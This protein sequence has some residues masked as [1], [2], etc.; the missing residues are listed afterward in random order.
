MYTYP[1]CMFMYMY[2][3][4]TMS[5]NGCLAWFTRKTKRKT[6]KDTVVERE[7]PGHGRYAYTIYMRSL[8][9]WLETRLAQI[10]LNYLNIAQYCLLVK[11][12]EAIAWSPRLHLFLAASRTSV[13]WRV[14]SVIVLVLSNPVLF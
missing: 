12:V 1:T 5:Y 3:S 6:V 4:S 8:P 9:G 13:G 7:R 14:L 10:T 11:V 2:R